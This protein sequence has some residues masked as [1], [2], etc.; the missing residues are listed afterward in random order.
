M[1]K[2]TLRL[3]FESGERLGPGK[4]RLL[5]LIAQHGSISAAGREMGMSYRRAWL[6]VDSLNRTFEATVVESRPG[7]RGGGGASLTTLGES[8][9]SHYRAMER[10]ATRALSKPLRA[11]DKAAGENTNP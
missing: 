5:E 7:G 1:P 8:I 10:E 3:D 11:L 9:V 4:A 2:L 6:L